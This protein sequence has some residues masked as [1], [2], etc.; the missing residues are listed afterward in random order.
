M[1][2]WVGLVRNLFYPDLSMR[3]LAINNMGEVSQ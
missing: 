2:G 3:T 1:M